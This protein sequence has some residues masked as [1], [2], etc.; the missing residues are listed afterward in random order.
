MP[1]QAQ[2]ATAAAA[3]LQGGEGE[4][5]SGIKGIV[6]T[7]AIFL[8]LQTCEP[9]SVSQTVRSLRSPLITAR[10]YQVRNAIRV[11]LLNFMLGLED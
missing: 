2:G 7:L 1:P 8:L 11:F 3:R 5:K 10:S 9:Y 4:E 6:K